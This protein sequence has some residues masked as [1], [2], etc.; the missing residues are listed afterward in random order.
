MCKIGDIII[1]DKY[2]DH[3]KSIRSHSFVDVSDENGEIHG[4]SYDFVANVLSSFKNE[5]Q[6]RR[7]LN[8]PGNFPL[9]SEDVDTDPNNG[10]SGYIKA[11]QWYYFS[12]DKISYMVIGNMKSDIFNLLIDYIEESDF[13]IVDIVD[14]L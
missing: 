2:K 10:K 1:V 9:T 14:N 11:D 5:E 8:Y 3:G 7:K 6:K 4:L 13:E 12:K